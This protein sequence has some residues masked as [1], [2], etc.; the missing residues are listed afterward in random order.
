MTSKS[1]NCL[2]LF[3]EVNSDRYLCYSTGG[4]H[5]QYK[6]EIV[7]AEEQGNSQ[8]MTDLLLWA[9]DQTKPKPMTTNR[10]STH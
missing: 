7:R 4:D 2:P 3:R 6:G 8:A 1:C 10:S 5:T 9:L